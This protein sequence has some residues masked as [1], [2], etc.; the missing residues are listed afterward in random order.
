MAV[1]VAA[2]DEGDVI[3]A[4][5][6]NLLELEYPRELLTV[7]VAS[8]GS[9][10]DT[11][12]QARAAGADLVLELE[13][14]GKIVAQNSAVAATDAEILA[15]SDANATWAPDALQRLVEAFADPRRRLRLRARR[16]S[17]TR[18][19]TTSK[20]A[21]WRYE[22]W[23][24]GLES[25][26]G[27]VT[28][29]NGAIYAVRRSAYLPLP[30]SRS[31]D[32][33]FPFMLRKRGLRSVFAPDA[34]SREPMV[35]TISG[36]FAR[37]RRMMAGVWDIVIG[38]GM[39]SLRGYGP[40]FGFQ[41]ASHRLLRYASPLLH[42]IALV[43][44]IALL[45]EGPVYVVT[46]ALQLALLAAALAAGLGRSRILGVCRYY[47]LVTASIALGLWDRLRSGPP[48]TW[49]RAEGTR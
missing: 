33:S 27:G 10:D 24:R 28:A 8:D 17:A 26:L 23:V 40:M 49:E 18:P 11:A 6:R 32:L 44:N 25:A 22:L 2:H 21:Y 9:A 38:D 42:L 36:E 34:V 3:A 5:V 30:A 20:G 1:V 43:A 41:I 19:A 47:V 31:H 37:K 15:F 35:P 13:R 16:S 7:V 45:G 12:E 14:R 48:G 46:L 4:K 29:G 39:A